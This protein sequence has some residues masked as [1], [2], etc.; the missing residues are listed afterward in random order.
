MLSG[1]SIKNKEKFSKGYVKWERVMYVRTSKPSGHH[2]LFF[3]TRITLCVCVC[4]CVCVF[5]CDKYGV[6]NNSSVCTGM[7]MYVN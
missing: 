4:V 3:A 5:V 6:H 7:Y 1:Q 2:V